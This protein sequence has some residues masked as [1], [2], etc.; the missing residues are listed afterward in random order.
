MS[1]YRMCIE[2]L[3]ILSLT[4]NL[5]MYVTIQDVYREAQ[6]LISSA[7]DDKENG[8]SKIQS[9]W[10]LIGAYISLGI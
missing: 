7:R 3:R 5:C 10:A 9:G 6:N 8:L 2:R 4:L 1:L